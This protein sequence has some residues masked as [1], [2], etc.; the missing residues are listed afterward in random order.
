MSLEIDTRDRE[1]HTA[2]G[3]SVFTTRNKTDEE[4]SVGIADQVV[5]K[6]INAVGRCATIAKELTEAEA[7]MELMAH[8]FSVLHINTIDDSEKWLKDLRTCRYAIEGEFRGVAK[9]MAD[10]TEYF[11][12]AEVKEAAAQL[13]ELCDVVERVAKLHADPKTQNLVEALLKL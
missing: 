13:R 9:T 10:I 4:M 12:K 8:K 2:P 6:T 5:K 7:V 3:G 1:H 11:K